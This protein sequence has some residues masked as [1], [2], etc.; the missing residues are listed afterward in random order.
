M[1]YSLLQRII[2][3]IL[4]DFC[5]L[6]FK[7]LFEDNITCIHIAISY[8][9]SQKTSASMYVIHIILDVYR[10]SV[11]RRFVRPNDPKSWLERKLT[12]GAVNAKEGQGRDKILQ[13]FQRKLWKSIMYE[14]KIHIRFAS[15]EYIYIYISAVLVFYCPFP[16]YC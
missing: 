11:E 1:H 9:H 6:Q 16:L 15:K 5:A 2:T 7:I 14:T 10:L 12:K 3:S 4:H 8:I 13:Q